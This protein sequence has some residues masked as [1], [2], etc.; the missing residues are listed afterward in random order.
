[1]HQS[2]LFVHTRRSATLDLLV[3]QLKESIEKLLE[4]SEKCFSCKNK[5]SGHYGKQPSNGISYNE[6]LERII[7]NSKRLIDGF[8]G[9]GNNI[10]NLK[11]DHYVNM[12]V[13]A[14]GESCCPRCIC[15]SN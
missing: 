10:G 4:F 14:I 3:R 15:L 9:I 12:V 6:C 13:D 2:P 7:E 11:R 8:I 1:M 5:D